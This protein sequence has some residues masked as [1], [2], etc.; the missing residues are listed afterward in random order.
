MMG[1][2][3]NGVAARVID[4]VLVQVH[5]GLRPHLHSES[6]I[7]VNS[8]QVNYLQYITDIFF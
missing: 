5:G 3:Q 8:I 1:T 2:R 4:V 6:S 7:Y